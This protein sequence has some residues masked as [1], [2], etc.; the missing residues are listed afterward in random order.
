MKTG[1]SRGKNVNFDRFVAVA[2]SIC[3]ERQIDWK[4]EVDA[5][6]Y[7]VGGG[8]WDLNAIAGSSQQML[9]KSAFAVSTSSAIKSVMPAIMVASTADQLLVVNAGV[10]SICALFAGGQKAACRAGIVYCR[11]LA[12]VH[13]DVDVA[14]PA[15]T[16][17][18]ATEAPIA[19]IGDRGPVSR[20]VGP[21]L[22]YSLD[23]FIYGWPHTGENLLFRDPDHLSS[24]ILCFLGALDCAAEQQYGGAKR[25]DND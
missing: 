19:G 2:R 24:G 18:G 7:V 20:V 5:N 4:I 14:K 12:L 8:A 16:D 9:A 22:G 10:H 6:G 13:H 11:D 15:R 23:R 21:D 3:S 1:N 25:P 17:G